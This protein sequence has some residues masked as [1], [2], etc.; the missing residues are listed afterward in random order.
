MLSLVIPVYNER[1]ALPDLV[2]EVA[3]VCETMGPWEAIVVDDGSEDGTAAAVRDLQAVHSELVL[4]R[5]RHNCG[6]SAALYAGFERTRGDVV[7]TLDGDGQDD[8]AEIPRL[9]AKLEEGYD[10]VSGWKRER[11]DRLGKR[12]ASRLFNRTTALLSG[13]GLHDFNCGL[14]AYRGSAIRE[15]PLYGEMHRYVPVLGAS[16]GWRIAE[17]DVHHRPRLHGSSKF[18]L[19]R[20]V[21]GLLDLLTVLFLSRFRDRPLHLFGGIGLALLM[22]GIAICAYLSVVKIAGGEAIGDRPLLL[23]GVLLCVVGVQLLSLGLIGE[24]V[25]ASRSEDR[26]RAARLQVEEVAQSPAGPSGESPAP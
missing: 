21:R 18:G 19:E 9:V 24:L 23:L 17:I 25:T 13:V 6:K 4:V 20:Y 2:R 22:L 1:D 5:L 8:P 7:V 16:R 26:E 11:A 3:S 10:L 15:L 12:A 14:K